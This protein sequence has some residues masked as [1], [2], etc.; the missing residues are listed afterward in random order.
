MNTYRQVNKE[1]RNKVV[2]AFLT[3]VLTVTLVVM[4]LGGA[5]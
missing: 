2:V 4:W 5:L 3:A 1:L